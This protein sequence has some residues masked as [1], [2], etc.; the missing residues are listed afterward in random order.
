MASNIVLQQTVTIPVTVN[1]SDVE[2]DVL[3]EASDETLIKEI[4]YRGFSVT[5][6]NAEGDDEITAAL[7]TAL[8]T[9]CPFKIA[10]A[11]QELVYERT[12]ALYE[13]GAA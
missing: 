7:R 8:G 2:Q 5:A 1:L 4:R 11:A 9:R 12:G 13:V 6:Q 3:D 10:K